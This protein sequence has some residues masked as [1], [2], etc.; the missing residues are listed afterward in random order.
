M[1]SA[2]IR[3][4]DRGGKSPAGKQLETQA[5]SNSDSVQNAALACESSNPD[6]IS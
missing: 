2:T 5:K 3:K 1:T 4:R 6:I